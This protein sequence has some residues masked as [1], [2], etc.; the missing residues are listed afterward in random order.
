MLLR[1]FRYTLFGLCAATVVSGQTLPVVADAYVNTG[2]PSGNYGNASRL[3]VGGANTAYLQFD[4][5]SMPAATNVTSVSLI[6]YVN[7]IQ[8]GGSIQVAE[9]SGPWSESAIA[10]GNAPA[11]GSIV[12]TIS[13][14]ANPNFVSID[15]TSSVV[16]WLSTPSLN[17]GFLIT[18]SGAAAVWLDSKENVTTSHLAV[19][20]FQQAGVQGA[21]G[22]AGATGVAGSPGIPGAT[23]ATGPT[24]TL[25]AVTTYDGGAIYAQGSVVTYLGSSYVSLSGGNTGNNPTSGT[26]WA[27][28]AQQGAAGATGA[29]GATGTPGATGGTGAAG[30]PGI[31]GATGATGPTG[32]LGLVTTYDGGATYAQ[33]SVVTYLGS[34]YVSLSGGNTGNNPTSGTPWAVLAQQGAAGAT[35]ATGAAGA[36][37]ATGGAGVAGSPGISGAS[38]ATGPTGTLGVVTTYDGGATYAQGSVV[39]YLGSSYVSLS[40]G[41]AGNTPTSGT[42]WAVLAQQGATGATGAAGAAG[43]TGATGTAGSPGISGATGATG[44]TGT[45]GVVT[46]YDGGATYAQGSVVTYLGSSY[47]SLS[48]GNTGNNPTSGTP[49]AVLA[50]Q[51]APGSNGAAGATGATGASG[52]TGGT[53]AAGSQGITG[54]TGATGSTGAAGIAGP[55]GAAGV[56]SAGATGAT[57]PQGPTGPATTS[58]S[59]T[60]G[61]TCGANQLVKLMQFDNGVNGQQGRVVTAAISDSTRIFGVAQASAVSGTPVNVISSGTASCIFDNVANQGDYVQAST[62]VAGDCT[63]AGSGYPTSGQLIGIVLTA[64]DTGVNGQT[65]S[66]Y[67]FGG[68]IR[69][70]AGATG[71][72]GAT[73]ATG[74]TGPAGTTGST[75]ST[76][77][78]GPA[79]ATGTAGATGPAGATGSPGSTGAIGATGTGTA[80]PSGATG[81]TGATGLSG[82]AVFP[83]TVANNFRSVGGPGTLYVQLGGNGLSR[84][85]DCPTNGTASTQCVIAAIPPSC[86]TLQNLHVQLAEAPGQAVTWTLVYTSPGSVTISAGPTC[87]TTNTAGG[88]CSSSNTA[89]VSGLGFVSLQATFSSNFS[90]TNARFAAYGE[91]Q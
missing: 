70:T 59:Y 8:T 24:G 45:L 50:Q 20:S 85:F 13:L 66:I 28:L 64:S 6:L 47:V 7:S 21:T 10:A 91:C 68:E 27:V 62:S 2:F 42:P 54:A 39:T 12:G 22:A 77:A 65:E 57:G 48:G 60:C 19:L 35:G 76:G 30:S 58:A 33:G 69:G 3:A 56:G 71:P 49:W 63:D 5:S 41:N 73:G 34:S 37:G 51:G 89:S 38:G 1:Y 18:G 14:P 29:T 44:P 75:G 43:A 31:P 79:G 15:V 23:G 84:N 55:S 32:T 16:K 52:A 17:N 80:G 78:T 36:S 87:S 26:P 90:T 67:V 72:A 11:A 46:T 88:S 74:A 83:F 25:G 4:L 53:G 61:G 86:T 40:D 82:N 9:A 81:A